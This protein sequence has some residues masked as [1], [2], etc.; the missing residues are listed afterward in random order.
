MR[1]R[2]NT[3]GSSTPRLDLQLTGSLHLRD[4]P[5]LQLAAAVRNLGSSRVAI[6]QEG[7]RCQVLLVRR[8]LSETPITLFPLFM[9]RDSIA[10]GDTVGDLKL[11]RVPLPPDDPDL[12]SPESPRRLRRYGMERQHGAPRRFSRAAAAR[13]PR[14]HPRAQSPYLPN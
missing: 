7:T 11:C 9:L 12:D 2:F 1:I 5:F 3:S 13:R 6:E 8:D 4:E 14:P 10:P